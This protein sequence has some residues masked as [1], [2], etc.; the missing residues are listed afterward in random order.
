MMDFTKPLLRFSASTHAPIHRSVRVSYSALRLS[1]TSSSTG[2]WVSQLCQPCRA[3]LKNASRSCGDIFDHLSR[4]SCRQVLDPHRRQG[5]PPPKN[6]RAKRSRP[7]ACQNVSKGSSNRSGI[8]AFQS[9]MV[10][11]LKAAMAAKISGINKN[12]IL[13]YLKVVIVL[14]V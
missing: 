12:L 9:S 6:K 1:P 11:A 10:T 5:W 13:R 7:N 4:Q 14:C 8:S 3:F 2:A